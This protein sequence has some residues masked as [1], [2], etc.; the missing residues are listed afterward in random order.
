MRSLA[1]MIEVMV[2]E[3]CRAHDYPLDG[4]PSETLPIAKRS[5]TP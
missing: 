1:N 5:K 2:V 3:Y 4:V